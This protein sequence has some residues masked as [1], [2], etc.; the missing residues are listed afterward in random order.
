MADYKQEGN[1]YTAIFVIESDRGG[2]KTYRR[3]PFDLVRFNV[4]TDPDAP[5]EI[6]PVGPQSGV[7][8]NDSDKI[9]ENVWVVETAPWHPGRGGKQDFG[10]S[11]TD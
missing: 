1:R 10:K 5:Q 2:K 7:G 9:Y 8:L 11:H 6:V 3:N 4:D